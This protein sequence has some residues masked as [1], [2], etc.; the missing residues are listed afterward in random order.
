MRKT[1]LKRISE[2]KREQIKDEYL[3]RVLL[4]KR[5]HGTWVQTSQY[6]GYCE[7]ICEECGKPPDW[8]GLHP[9]EEIRRGQG[10]KLSLENSRMLCMKCHK[11]E[12]HQY[13]IDVH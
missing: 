1:P 10:G 5:A 4:C 6:G 3:I 9:H 2:K 11:A 7:G 8:R 12:H 13:E